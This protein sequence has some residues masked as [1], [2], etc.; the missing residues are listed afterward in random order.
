MWSFRCDFRHVRCVFVLVW[1]SDQSW[2]ELWHRTLVTQALVWHQWDI[3]QLCKL[4]R[5]THISSWCGLYHKSR[6]FVLVWP[7]VRS[8]VFSSRC[9]LLDWTFLTQMWLSLDQLCCVTFTRLWSWCEHLDLSSVMYVMFLSLCD[10]RQI[11][12]V[13][14]WRDLLDSPFLIQI[15]FVRMWPSLHEFCCVTFLV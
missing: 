9:D 4:P 7:F 8:V 10:L 2:C 5:I 1:P 14:S 15:V 13:L 12:H 3:G 11:S 6:V